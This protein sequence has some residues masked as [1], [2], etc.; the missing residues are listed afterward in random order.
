MFCPHCGTA[1]QK[2]DAF[3]RRCGQWLA[4]HKSAGH[5]KA[6]TP[7]HIMRDMA[8]FSGVNALLALVSAIVLYSTYLGSKDAKW[9]VYVAAA[10]SLVIAIHQTISFFFNLQ[11]RRRFAREGPETVQ[12]IRPKPEQALMPA[13]ITGMLIDQ[14]SVTERTT[15]LLK[16]G[17]AAEEPGRSRMG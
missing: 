1:E 14:P 7:T 9:S 10:C 15:E 16:A 12:E 2:P 3:C 6:R 5:H 17:S 13:P 8:V 11:L 4:N